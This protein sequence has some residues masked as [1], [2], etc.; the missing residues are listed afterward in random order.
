MAVKSWLLSV[1]PRLVARRS[2]GFIL[3]DHVQIQD[4]FFQNPGSRCSY[5]FN[6]SAQRTMYSTTER[7]FCEIYLTSH[8][9]FSLAV[10]I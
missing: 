3:F 6:S 10:R 4:Q 2:V 8:L 5:N 7:L 9:I 1:Y